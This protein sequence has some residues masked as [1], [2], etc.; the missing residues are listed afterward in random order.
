MSKKKKKTDKQ[1]KHDRQISRDKRNTLRREIKE[2]VSLHRNSEVFHILFISKETENM[3]KVLFNISK[4]DKSG[5]LIN[6]PIITQAMINNFENK[7]PK[8]LILHYFGVESDNIELIEGTN[9]LIVKDLK[10]V[11]NI[12]NLV[13]IMIRPYN[14]YTWYDN[15]CVTTLY[16]ERIFK[17]EKLKDFFVVGNDIESIFVFQDTITEILIYRIKENKINGNDFLNSYI[18]IFFHTSNIE[19]GNRKKHNNSV[20]WATLYNLIAKDDERLNQI[21]ANEKNEIQELL[22]DSTSG[23]TKKL[24]LISKKNNN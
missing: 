6:L 24:T 7:N 17:G 23:N 12:E 4:L 2:N 15:N 19:C 20:G 9:L 5:Y 16:G 21:L 13:E 1:L 11:N 18:G 14:E 3:E 22:S 10:V 8:D